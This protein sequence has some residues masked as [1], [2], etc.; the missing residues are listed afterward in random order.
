M[1]VRKLVW[2]IG[3]MLMLLAVPTYS[4]ANLQDLPQLTQSKKHSHSVPQDTVEV[5][6]LLR[7]ARQQSISNQHKALS[8]CK[9][10]LIVAKQKKYIDGIANAYLLLANINI[11]LA[12]S[13]SVT[14]FCEQASKLYHTI[15]NQAGK[16]DT[17]VTLGY[18]AYLRG[19]YEIAMQYYLQGSNY[20]KR[21]E[22]QLGLARIENNMGLVYWC[23]GNYIGALNC[24]QKVSLVFE[25]LK[26]KDWYCY[27]ENNLGLIYLDLHRD[28]LALVHFNNSL[29]LN[30]QSGSQLGIATDYVNIAEAYHHMKQDSLAL[31]YYQ[32]SLAISRQQGDHEGIAFGLR[33]IGSLKVSQGLLLEGK[34]YLLEGLA[35]FKGIDNKEGMAYCLAGL[36]TVYNQTDQLALANRYAKECMKLALELESKQLISNAA[37]VLASTHK[38]QKKYNKAL[39]YYELFEHYKDSLLNAENIQ[40]VEELKFSFQL[41]KKEVE[42]TELRHE[43]NR[44]QAKTQKQFMLILIVGAGLLVALFLL[45]LL[46]KNNRVKKRTNM[47]LTRQKDHIKQQNASL[48]TL[49]EEISQ[50]RDYLIALNATAQSLQVQILQQN[51]ELKLTNEKLSELDQEKDGLMSVV[52]HDLRAPLNRA[53]GLSQLVR[54]AGPINGD[55]DS[56][57]QLIDKVTKDG[58]NL[59]DDLLTLN[60]AHQPMNEPEHAL[61]NLTDWMDTLLIGFRPQAEAKRISLHNQKLSSP[62]FIDTD[63]KALTRILDNLLSNALKFTQP[64]KNVFIVQEF[65]QTSIRISIRDEGPGVSQEDQ[66]KMFKQFQKL[67]PKPTQGE[68]STGLGLAIVKTLTAKIGAKIQVQSQLGKGT[69][70]ILVLPKLMLVMPQSPV[71]V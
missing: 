62:Y 70:F 1:V 49:N 52:A 28:S 56:Y 32:Q 17:D 18:S 47:I 31:P 24:F 66:Q 20:Y 13:D 48:A 29:E 50:Q 9:K 7:L 27:A 33:G 58:G 61:I 15:G 42:N 23:Q 14:I 45:V 26:A 59:I 51:E 22:N 39:A 21:V 30:R 40:K 53:S 8:Y 68:S 12:N 41:K 11:T 44:Q 63:E 60:Q 54:L 67:T 57:L 71:A 2:M 46:W 19:N 6:Q 25:K 35:A 64:G 43:K 55:Q 10:A 34:Q 3:S 16:A 36:A 5:Q 65:T 38:K 4:L 37:E 69:K